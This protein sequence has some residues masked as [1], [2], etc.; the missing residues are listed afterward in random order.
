MRIHSRSVG[1]AT[2]ILMGC[3]AEWPDPPPI[4]TEVLL[5]EHEDWRSNRERRLITPPGGSVL[6]NGLWDIPEG[7]TQF[8]SDP[9]LVMSLP[10][11]DSPPVAGVLRRVG[12][13]VTLIPDPDSGIRLRTPDSDDS[14]AL[15]ETPVTE[16]QRVAA[17]LGKSS[18]PGA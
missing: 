5:A 17:A 13:V 4:A 11:E 1:A 14:G 7:E 10:A 12:Q 9:S 6:W 3:T 8:G 18:A 15:I 16:P 2:L